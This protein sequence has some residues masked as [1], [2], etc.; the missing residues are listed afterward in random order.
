MK[1][2]DIAN[3]T[4]PVPVFADHERM[5][6][7][8]GVNGR[9]VDASSYFSFQSGRMLPEASALIVSSS[10][11]G[12]A[13]TVG[14]RSVTY[15]SRYGYVPSPGPG[16]ASPKLDMSI[17][18]SRLPKTWLGYTTLRTVIL[19]PSEW[20]E[21]NPAQQDALL[22]WTASGG[23]LIFADGSLD[24]LLPAGQNAVGLGKLESSRPYYFG[25][26]HLMKS[27]DI[28]SKGLSA[29]VTEIDAA[30]AIP[31]WGL[32]A[33]RG[34]DW[35]WIAE[36]NFRLP[37]TGAGYV[38]TRA[39]L[40]ILTLFVALIGP[41]NYIYLWRRRRQ[42]LLVLTVPLI[43]GVF[44]LLL[45]GYGVLSEGFDIRA[46]AVTFTLLDQNSKKAATRASVSLYPGGI[47]RGGLAFASDTAILSL[48]ADGFG[49]R[50]MSLDFTGEQ[51]YVSGLLEPRTP[52]N[53]EQITFQPARQRLNFERNG[54]ELSIVNGLGSTIQRL[55]YRE[56]G[57]SY[58]LAE[59]LVAGERA[60]LKVE[61]KR[62]T[63]FF[64]LGIRDGVKETPIS[65]I[66][67]QQVV[68][69]QPDGSYLAVLENSPF[70]DSGAKNPKEAQSFHVVLGLAGGQP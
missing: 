2:G 30:V 14:T 46:R 58:G 49:A 24:M 25:N 21:M 42:V 16:S 27:A 67:F 40:S 9:I 17:E 39:Y 18:P 70:W 62:G 4:L 47:T 50:Q 7:R 59:P 3:F 34:R 56:G 6:L 20:K 41:I 44:I 61:T 22:M 65:P 12:L 35:A 29:A 28:R 13:A 63:D 10:S 66:K 8:I 51:R 64:A 32:P 68:E 43:S 52:S 57:V 38:P 69:Q 19:G 15:T 26:I 45:A 37:I 31:D 60:T 11:S 54:N 1:R 48:G 53:F 5:Q 33:V 36:R 23:D 55:L